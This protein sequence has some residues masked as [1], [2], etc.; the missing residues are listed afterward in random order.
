MKYKGYKMVF[1]NGVHFGNNTIEGSE[2]I[3]HADTLFSALCHE[4]IK[5]GMDK[6]E[7]L[8]KFVKN[9]KLLISDAMPYCGD[10]LYIPKPMKRIEYEDQG[11]SS[12]KKAFKN[13]S[14]IPVDRL[15]EYLMGKLDV[16]KERDRFAK[17]GIMYSRNMVSIRGKEE[18]EP[19][20]VGIFQF[21]HG[22]GLY[23]IIGYE[24]DEQQDLMEELLV[25][26][27]FAGIG[28]KRSSGLGRFELDSCKL[29]NDTLRR[30]EENGN[31]YITLSIAL[32][33]K[34]EMENVLENSSYQLIKRSGFVASDKY[35]DEYLRKRDI[36][37]MNAGSCF[38]TKFKGD[39]FDVSLGGNHPVYRYAKPFLMEVDL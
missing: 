28:G 5:N 1:Q 30:L 11:N 34:E 4:A 7:Q 22:N 12:V 14:Y 15:N 36:Y 9:D 8:L 38:S 23:I 33:Q 13:L 19:Y 21:H 20:R 27:S 39:V 32:P 2:Y 6:F 16:Q 35:A 37:V 26:L 17:L 29:S 10:T 24:S 3:F 18:T 25:Q 31:T